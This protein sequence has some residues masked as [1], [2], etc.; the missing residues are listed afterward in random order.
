MGTRAGSIPRLYA[1]QGS[2]TTRPPEGGAIFRDSSGEPTGI[3]QER[4]N[5]LADRAV[6]AATEADC[7]AAISRA[8]QEAFARGVTGV[9]SLEQ[10]SSYA[11]FKRARERGSLAARVVM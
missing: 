6:P 3:M 2:D 4:A 8:Q 9:E 1:R 5:E 11:A 10:A 7:D